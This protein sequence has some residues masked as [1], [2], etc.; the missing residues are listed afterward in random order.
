MNKKIY[1]PPATTSI[2]INAQTILAGS[3]TID[4]GTTDSG[5]DNPTPDSDNTYW[6]E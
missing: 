5:T 3:G 6:T 4:R 1:I 2:K